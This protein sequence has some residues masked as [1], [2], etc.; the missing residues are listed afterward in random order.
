MQFRDDFLWG[1]ATAAN[2]FEGG[3]REGG[4]GL[5]TADVISNGTRKEPRKISLNMDP[6]LYYPS[7]QA[8]DFYHHYKEDIA[9]MGEMGFKVYRMSIA[10]TRIFPQGD[11]ETP[12]E[13]G[14]LFYDHVFDE[15]KR[16]GI[17][18]MVTLSHYEMPLEL[19]KKYNGWADRR[20]IDFFMK[21][22]RVVFER[23]RD[24]VKYW[25]TFN[26]INSAMFAAGGYMGLGILNDQEKEQIS[27]HDQKDIPDVRFQGLHHALLASAKAVKLGHEINPDFRIGCMLAMLVYYPYSCN[28]QDMIKSQQE[29]QKFNY[30]CGDVQVRGA[31]P[32]FSKRI[33]KEWGVQI[34]MEEGDE[35]ILKEGTV[36][37]I[38]LSYYMSNCVSSDLT[39]ECTE[40]NIVGGVK[41]PYLKTTDW[42]W[43]IDPDG[44]RYTLN[45]I[46]GRYNCPIII[47]ENGLG[48]Y[49]QVEEDGTI[50][51][52]YRI[53]YLRDHIEAIGQALEDGVDVFGYTPWGCIDLVSSGTGEMKKRYGFVYVDA[54][55]YGNGSFAR[56]RKDSFYWYKKVIAS[57]GRDLD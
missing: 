34:R 45:E 5:S 56:S 49:D 24:K 40:G 17:E 39:K 22:C 13:E 33:W 23:Y 57:N 37:F 55:D 53:E 47:V 12:N 27:L 16:Y 25:L 52:P 1:G 14:L 51:D 50:H 44:L 42:G 31:Y 32:S 36:D 18:P 7:H 8:S 38:S 26:E 9:L 54:D 2:Q 15:L 30:Y 19:T 35:Q 41:N 48:A 3:F 11:E 28:P 46:Y 29:W 20:V 4:K 6:S 10:W 43:Q 21:Y